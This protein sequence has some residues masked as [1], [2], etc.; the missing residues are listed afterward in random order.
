MIVAASLAEIWRYVGLSFQP[1]ASSVGKTL[2]KGAT[3]T[4]HF[5]GNNRANFHLIAFRP[6]FES[7]VLMDK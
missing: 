5:L 6:S 4:D 7:K 1:E 2:E 3:S